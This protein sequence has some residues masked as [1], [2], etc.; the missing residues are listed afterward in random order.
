M[1]RTG[2]LFLI[3][4]LIFAQP[5]EKRLEAKW[6]P[7]KSFSATIIIKQMS[8]ELS[9][10]DPNFQYAF[11]AKETHF[12]FRAPNMFRFEGKPYGFF[13][14]VYIINGDSSVINVPGLRLKRESQVEADK[15]VLSLDFG[16]VSSDVWQYFSL[17]V[18]GEDRHSLKIEA[19]P[20]T[21]GRK[22]IFWLDKETLAVEKSWKF[23]SQGNLK[24]SYLFENFQ[25]YPSGVFIPKRM[26]V[27]SPEGKCVGIV[28][29]KDMKIN[30]SLSLDLF[31]L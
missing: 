12:Y 5:L 2:F 15:R 20:K 21:G 27:Y 9:K 10:I 24:V 16:F 7:L 30:P 18:V 1:R 6:A 8:K 23:D 11:R 19:T 28:E 22:R 17:K 3:A 4:S 29:Y 26:K 31:A 14:T 25:K 13:W